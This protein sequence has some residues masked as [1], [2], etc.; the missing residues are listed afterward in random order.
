MIV[1]IVVP[2][3]L[4]SS[5]STADCLDDLASIVVDGAGLK[6]A[7]FGFNAGSDDFDVALDET[8]TVVGSFVGCPDLRAVFSRV[9][10]SLL[11]AIWPPLLE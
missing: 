5:A 10:L 3:G 4:R 8:L 9:D 1:A 6:E 11:V 2:P 7:D